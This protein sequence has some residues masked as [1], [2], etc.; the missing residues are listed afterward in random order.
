MILRIPGTRQ[1][2]VE[3]FSTYFQPSSSNL[4]SID[5]F[6][7][8][9]TD[10]SPPAAT[11]LVVLFQITISGYHPVNTHGLDSIWSI[12]PAN[13]RKNPFSPRGTNAQAAQRFPTVESK[14]IK[15][16]RGNLLFRFR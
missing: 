2:K 12:M 13:T 6:L 11:D 14:A 9:K 1:V 5:S 8:V 4:E 16:F 15:V 3:M 10:K 7:I